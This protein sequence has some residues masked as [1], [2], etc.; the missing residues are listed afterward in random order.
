MTVQRYSEMEKIIGNIKNDLRNR[1]AENEKHFDS[2]LYKRRVKIEKAN[3]WLDSF[4]ALLVRFGT[5][6]ITWKKYTLSRFF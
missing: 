4:R 5:L 1:D 6:N 2:E 3:V